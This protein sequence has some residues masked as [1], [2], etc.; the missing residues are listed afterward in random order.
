MNRIGSRH[1]RVPTPST[2]N[3]DGMALQ[4]NEGKYGH[5]NWV[6]LSYSRVLSSRCG[7]QVR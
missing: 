3:R 7:E 1:Q 6:E 5:S 2:G 4:I